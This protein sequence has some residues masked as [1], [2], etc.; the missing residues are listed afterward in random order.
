MA[1]DFSDATVAKTEK[2]KRQKKVKEVLGAKIK[3]ICDSGSKRNTGIKG[4]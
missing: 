1:S 3:N 2:N 4:M